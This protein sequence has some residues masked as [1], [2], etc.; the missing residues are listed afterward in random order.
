MDSRQGHFYLS[1]IPDR[2][3]L[4]TQHGM[5]SDSSAGPYNNC[6][7]WIPETKKILKCR[8]TK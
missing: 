8:N 6:G 4:S 3:L 5:M 1:P 7:G 2:N